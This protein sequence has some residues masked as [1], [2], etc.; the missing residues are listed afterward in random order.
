M[1][2]NIEFDR[3]GLRKNYKFDV[4]NV[5]LQYGPEKVNCSQGVKCEQSYMILLDE[6]IRFL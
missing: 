1:T 4:Y 5:G 2:G 3:S 6:V